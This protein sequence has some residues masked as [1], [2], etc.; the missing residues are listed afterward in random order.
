M[1]AFV[2]GATGFV[3]AAVVRKPLVAGHQVLGLARSDASA[4]TLTAA[5]TEVHRGALEDLDSLHA[6]AT[7]DRHCPRAAVRR[8]EHAGYRATWT[9]EVIGK[10]ALA[11]RS[12]LPAPAGQMTFGAPAWQ[13]STARLGP[14]AR[15]G[16]V[17]R[18][19]TQ[20]RGIPA[21]THTPKDCTTCST[22]TSS[23]KRRRPHCSAAPFVRSWA[24]RPYRHRHRPRAPL[25]DGAAGHE[26]AAERLANRPALWGGDRARRRPR[27]L[28]PAEPG[29]G[30]GRNEPQSGGRAAVLEEA[31][32]RLRCQA[33]A[34]AQAQAQSRRW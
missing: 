21:T 14:A 8:L 9:N 10:D 12:V 20:C 3:G 7:V 31:G 13:A 25:A 18:C 23:P 4:A 15:S 17:R 26:W 24:G 16:P 5:G 11:Q 33:Q 30:M 19:S 32:R 27:S 2:T 1:R 22:A 28:P 34:Q 29:L 6:G